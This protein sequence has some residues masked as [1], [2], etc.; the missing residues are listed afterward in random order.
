MRR[1]K[2][3]V[4]D[5]GKM[6]ETHLATNGGK[7]TKLVSFEHALELVIVLPGPLAKAFRKQACDILTRF[8]A[9]DQTLHAELD[10][11]ATSTA[12][13]HVLAR[14]AAPPGIGQPVAKRVCLAQPHEVLQA[15]HDAR[16]ARNYEHLCSAYAMYKEIQKD[17]SDPVARASFSEGLVMNMRAF[18]APPVM[19]MEVKFESVYKYV[20]CLQS[21]EQPDVVKIGHTQDVKSRISSVNAERR[22]KGI[23]DPLIY[24]YSVRSLDSVRDEKL[25]HAE[26]ATFRLPV[27][28]C[29]PLAS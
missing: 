29:S 6:P 20:Y 16:S 26:F 22:N 11:N 15:A 1:L 12:P 23:N 9:G 24:R 8:L 19:P 4:F 3:E 5:S 25:A 7:K 2:P 17:V 18:I 21:K 27:I 13:L 14:A 28:F 10:A